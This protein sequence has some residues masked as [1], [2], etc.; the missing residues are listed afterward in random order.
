MICDTCTKE[1]APKRSTAKYCSPKCRVYAARN[2]AIAPVIVHRE[3]GSTLVLGNSV[4]K[5]TKAVASLRFDKGNGNCK[6]HGA[7][8]DSR[9]RCLQKGCKYA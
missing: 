1:F 3:D 6:I 9:G 5:I 2:K 7:P 8:L 4:E